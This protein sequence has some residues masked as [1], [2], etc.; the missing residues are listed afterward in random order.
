[1][2]RILVAL[3]CA[4]LVSACATA[5]D[6]ISSS[7]IS[8]LQYGGYDCGQIREEMMRVSAKVREVAGAQK[9]QSNSDAWALGVGLVLFWPA[10]FFMVGGDQ[11]EELSRLKGEYDALQQAAIQKKC[12]VAQEIEDA[13]SQAKAAK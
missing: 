5:P 11:K 12:P 9:K 4:S 10:L 8:P 7:Y 13:K 3:I 6:K 2:K 1:M